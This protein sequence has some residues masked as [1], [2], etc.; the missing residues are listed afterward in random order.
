MQVI[1]F[2]NLQ[3]DPEKLITD[4]RLREQESVR[5]KNYS[6]NTSNTLNNRLVVVFFL[7]QPENVGWTAVR[8]LMGDFVK[9]SGWNNSDREKKYNWST[10]WCIKMSAGLTLGVLKASC[11]SACRL[12]CV[13]SYI[14]IRLSLR[15]YIN[16]IYSR[17]IPLMPDCMWAEATVSIHKVW[18]CRDCVFVR[19]TERRVRVFLDFSTLIAYDI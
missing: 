18:T 4:S 16:N 14:I 1:G 5:H 17:Q 12:W 2:T 13:L 19:R 7:L 10:S 9:L 11:Y 3:N 8:S 15:A 6:W